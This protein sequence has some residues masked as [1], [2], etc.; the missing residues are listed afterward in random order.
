MKLVFSD[1]LRSFLCWATFFLPYESHLGKMKYEIF[2]RAIQN[3][4]EADSLSY[5][6]PIGFVSGKTVWKHFSMIRWGSL[7][8]KN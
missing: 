2:R 8:K 3:E 4:W 6:K 5:R 1:S 7:I